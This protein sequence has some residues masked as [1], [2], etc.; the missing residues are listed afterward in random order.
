MKYLFRLFI[1]ISAFSIFTFAQGELDTTFGGS[2]AFV[3]NNG[4][5]GAIVD[6]KIQEDS[7]VISVGSCRTVDAI[8]YP[9]CLVRLTNTGAEDPAFGTGVGAPFGHVRTSIP[10]SSTSQPM[11]SHSLIVQND[12]KIVVLAFATVSGLP[13]SYLIRY[14]TSGSLDT[15]FGNQ[16]FKELDAFS[17]YSVNKMLKQPDEKMVIIGQRYIARYLPDG[18]IDN[19]FGV[20]GVFTINIDNFLATGTDLDLRNDGKLL[21]GGNRNGVSFVG[22]VN[23]DGTLDTSFGDSGYKII[24]GNSGIKALSISA[25]HKIAALGSSNL[26][27]RLMPDGLLDTSFDG[28]GSRQVFGGSSSFTAYD[29]VVTPSGRITVIGNILPLN[30]GVSVDYLIAR[31]VQD[32]SPDTTFSGDG[33]FNLNIFGQD[34]PRSIVLDREGK[35][36]IAGLSARG[37]VL[38][39]WENPYF[40]IAR[41]AAPAA[42][43]VSVSGKVT[44]SNGRFVVYAYV[45]LRRGSEI[46]GYTRTNPFGYFRFNNVPT[47]F[48]YTITSGT[49]N[50]RFNDQSILIDDAISD[51]QIIGQ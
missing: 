33:L 21:F 25:D 9:V 20:N 31:Y 14:N 18:T 34:S 7:K 40:S 1:I 43:N 23:A 6:S 37:T 17:L 22:R 24:D 42:Q 2:G 32:G 45:V 39:P 12:G 11:G 41:L 35:A 27:F 5:S 19:S 28:D 26:V 51:L 47:P 3:P 29:L 38:N 8:F 36:I 48:T 44:D 30:S 16:G 4:P 49:K 50:V 46:V 13:R 10:G 15:G